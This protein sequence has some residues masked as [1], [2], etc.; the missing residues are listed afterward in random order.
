MRQ[1]RKAFTLVEIMIVIT[2][3]ATLAA[4]AVSSMLR[5]RMNANEVAAIASCRA[6]ATG[7]QNYYGNINPHTYPSS[8]TNLTTPTSDPPYIDAVLAGGTR[9][10][11]TFAYTFVDT[12]HF[13]L[14]ADP[15]SLGRTG[16]RH[17]FVDETGVL[18]AN[19]TS[20][21]SASDPPIQ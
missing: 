21:A 3:I 4:L 12:E 16:V 13:R 6:I 17:F 9:Q 19:A 20:P 5:S 18:R 11:Y 10:G 7:N 8:L 1:K 2:I 15:E 14:Y